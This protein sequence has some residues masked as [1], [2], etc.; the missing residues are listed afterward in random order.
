[1][2]IPVKIMSDVKEMDR[3][4]QKDFLLDVAWEEIQHDM[5]CR[6]CGKDL[7][8]NNGEGELCLTCQANRTN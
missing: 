6:K 7:D 8:T 1:M 2:N 3:Q 4:H 5:A